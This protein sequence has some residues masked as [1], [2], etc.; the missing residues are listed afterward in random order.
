MRESFSLKKKGTPANKSG[1]NDRIRKLL[2]CCNTE[3][4]DAGNDHQRI[5]PSINVN[6]IKRQASEIGLE[7]HGQY[8]QQRTAPR[9]A[10]E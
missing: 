4:T 5:N 3:I 9:V 6:I 7:A 10:P 8:S 1:R 2:S